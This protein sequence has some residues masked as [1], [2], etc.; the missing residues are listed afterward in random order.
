MAATESGVPVE[1]LALVPRPGMDLVRV[2]AALLDGFEVVAVAGEVREAD[3]R[4]LS[5]RARSR[6]SVL[7]AFG[8][9]PGVE[10]ELTCTRGRWYGLGHGDGALREREVEIHA[11]GRG[12]ATRPVRLG[13]TL[14]R[15]V[16]G[17][18]ATHAP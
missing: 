1:R 14:P 18:P 11:R 13:V 6:G 4:R 8:R 9:W 15:A 7:L 2:V 12:A 5:A 3:A 17:G 10:V 16:T